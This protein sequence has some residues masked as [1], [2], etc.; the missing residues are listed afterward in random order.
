MASKPSGPPAPTAE[1]REQQMV[2]LAFDLAQRQLE[3]GSAS[4]QV[5]THYLKIGAL[6][7][8]LELANLEKENLLR[9]ARVDQITAQSANSDL[10]ERAIAAMTEYAGDEPEDHP[11]DY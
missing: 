11:V 3:D 4:A 6:Q 10:Y 1:G 8:R 5:I 2:S 7:H 9:Q